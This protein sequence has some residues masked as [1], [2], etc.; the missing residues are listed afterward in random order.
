[1][2]VDTDD[3]ANSG[4]P[5]LVRVGLTNVSDIPIYNPGITLDPG[6]NYIFQPGQQ[7]TY[8]TDFIQPGQTF[9]TAY[10]RLI[11]EITGTLDLSQSFVA[12]TGGNATVP[13]TIVSHPA[14]PPAQLPA[15]S[16]TGASD[17]IHLS[18]AAPSV[19]GITG[20]QIFYTPTQN[21]PFGSTPVA[22]LPASATSTV[23]D[24]GTSGFYAVATTTASGLTDYHG[25]V[26]VAAVQTGATLTLGRSTGLF[27]GY[28]EKVSGAGWSGGTSVTL[29]ECATT[30]YDAS[31]CNASNRVSVTLGTGKKAGTFKNSVLTLATG[32]IDTHGDTC[33]LAT[34]PSC[35]V[36]VTG[37]S[38][39][40]VASGP[41]GFI[42]PVAMATKMAAVKAN[43]VD[44]IKASG[45]PAGDTVTARE[46][47]SA[48]TPSTLASRCDI[49]TVITGIVSANGKV[50]FA[51]TGVT[52]R[53]G[54]AYSEVGSGTVVSGGPATLIVNDTTNP[55]IS[56]MIPI[57][58][59]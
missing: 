8:S 18:W 50:T 23:I 55:G 47:D 4:D 3:A 56:V 30:V 1:M 14:T 54:A 9:W 53:V 17:G 58:L 6:F 33:G 28:G 46:C 52:V 11:P 34:S 5:Y 13:S 32:T 21:T 26:Q 36:V 51:P 2:T 44:K 27:G 15:F 37:G 39:A 7:L 12:K 42:T 10:Y 16:G 24:H 43:S 41:L 48:A 20:Y 19:S 49:S 22:T 29:N 35:Y 40:S 38:G 25:L 57:T 59:V 45:F 31:S